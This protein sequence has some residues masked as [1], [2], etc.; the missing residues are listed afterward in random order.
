MQDSTSKNNLLY[1]K[2]VNSAI[3][4]F[5]LISDSVLLFRSFCSPF[6]V[7]LNKDIVYKC[8]PLYELLKYLF[9]KFD[10]PKKFFLQKLYFL[11]YKKEK[12][13]CQKVCLS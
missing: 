5:I 6:Y 1:N 12:F 2:T 13:S 4:T 11:F 8:N 9:K 7:S 10:F 3:I